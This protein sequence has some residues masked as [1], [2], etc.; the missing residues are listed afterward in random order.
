MG[1]S[2]EEMKIRSLRHKNLYKVLFLFKMSGN[3]GNISDGGSS[4]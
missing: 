2:C 1:H 4:K 3:D